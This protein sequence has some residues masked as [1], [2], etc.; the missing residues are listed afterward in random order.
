MIFLRA[1][2]FFLIAVASVSAGEIWQRNLTP[3]IPGS[4]P[5]PRPLRA[6]YGFGWEG[7]RAATAEFVFTSAPEKNVLKLEAKASTMGVVRSLWAMD[8]TVTSTVRTPNLRSIETRQHEKYRSKEK[9]FR[10]Q[11]FP[12]R[13]IER[14]FESTAEKNRTGKRTTRMPNLL[15][16][17][18]AFLFL[19]SLP[20]NTGDIESIVVL[21]A[22]KPYLARVTVLK[23]EKLTVPAGTF[24]AI[25]ARLEI[26]KIEKDLSLQPHSK[27]KNATAWVSDDDAR[28]LLKID[29]GIFVG[30]VWAELERI[31]S[32]EA[33]H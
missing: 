9:Y 33:D 20:L 7:L 12:D 1:A 4:F 13:V 25:K 5:P 31:E 16:M 32:L 28:N 2:I 18:G 15:D 24:D 21:P 22:S 26:W 30:S 23:R 3:F 29:A 19:R 6:T 8:A 27:F 11:F 10:L 17:A 14:R